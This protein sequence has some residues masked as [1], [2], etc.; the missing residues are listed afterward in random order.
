MLNL[1]MPLANRRLFLA[2]L[3]SL[4]V[5]PAMAE[6]QPTLSDVVHCHVS[7]R[8]GAARLD[9][10]QA[11]E[12]AVR[13]T[14]PG[15]TVLG[16]YLASIT[17]DVRVDIY[18]DGERVFSEGV[19]DEGVWGWNLGDSAPAAAGEKGRQALLQGVEFNLI[20][21]HRFP[22]RGQSLSLVGRE[23][24]NGAECHVIQ[25]TFANGFEARLYID[26]RT[27]MIVGRRDR[28]A[29]HPDLDSREKRIEGRFSEFRAVEGVQTPYLSEDFDMTSG[30]RIGRS[31]I[32]WLKHN[33]DVR[34]RISRT[35][36]ALPAP[37]ATP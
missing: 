1:K 12:Y 11:L 18:A 27:W 15:F 16:R 6:T 24:F 36:P 17:G 31:E 7:A 10:V 8:G 20:G 29:Y 3:A 22:E 33:P 37:E 14:E 9:A 23:M 25:T 5:N 19:D 28:R 21:L 4:G 34:G 32:F 26:P 2:G 13:V 35:A 30:E